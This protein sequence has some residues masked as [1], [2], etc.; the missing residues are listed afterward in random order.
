MVI[1]TL[2]ILKRRSDAVNF[3]W[4]DIA[5]TSRCCRVILVALLLT[6]ALVGLTPQ[7]L[8][9]SPELIAAIRQYKLLDHQGKY[10]DAE[11]FAKRALE[12]G[13]VEFGTSHQTYADLLSNLA[14]LYQSQGRYG[15]AEP[16][17]KSSLSIKEKA[18]GPDHPSLATSLMNLSE[19]Y[20]AQGRYGEAEPLYLGSLAIMEKSLGPDHPSIATVRN[21]LAE[22]YRKQGRYGEAEPLYKRSLVIAENTLGSGHRHVA[23]TLNN[24]AL[25]YQSQ[26][27][28]GEAEPLYLRS[29]AIREKVLDP[30]HPDVGQSLSNLAVLYM[31]QGRYGEAEPFYKRVLANWKKSLGPD[32]PNVGQS[33][34]NLAELYRKQG[35][36]AEAEPLYK[37]SLTIKEK[38]LVPDHPSVA[39][40]L[41]NLAL[42]YQSQG[43]YGEAEPLLKSSLSIS[44]KSLGPDHPN[45]A[46]SLNNLALLYRSQGKIAQSL[47]HIRRAAAIQRDRA[48]RTGGGEGWGRLSEQKSIRHTFLFHVQDA[49]AMSKT[50]PS[51][52]TA[53]IA[54]GFAS[55]QLATASSAGAAVSRMAARF[56]TGDDA[57]AGLVRERQDVA[58]RW[59]RLDGALV[60]AASKPPDRRDR[61]REATQRLELAKTDRRI[62]KIDAALAKSFPQYAELASPKP[63]PLD[64]LQELLGETEALLTYLVGSKRSFVFVVRRDRFLAKEVNLRAQELDDA[65]AVLRRGL[66]PFRIRS[67]TDV[68]PFNTTVAYEL[69]QKIFEPIE[70]LLEGARQVFVVPDGALQSLPLGVL[71]SQDFDGEIK[72]PGDYGKVPWL[73]R[74]YAMT[75]LPSVSSLRA[76]RTFARRT[77]A[78]RSF[79][80]V[81]DPQLDGETG[82]SR[83]V[84]LASLFTLRGVA[85]VASVRR[86]PSLPDTYEELQSMA[87]S[88]GADDG[89]LMVGADA[90]ETKIKSMTLTDY[91]VLTF[92]THGLLAG[93]LTG[94]SEP[95]LVLTP[96]KEGTEL[97]DGLLTASEVAQLKLDADWVILS[98]CNTAAADGTPGAE[99]LSGLAKAFFYAGARSLLVSHWPVVSDAAVK[100]TT[101][102]LRVLQE[103]GVSRAEA[104]RQAKLALMNGAE[105]PAYAHPMFWA[106]F[107]LVGEGQ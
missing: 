61:A 106:P 107:V 65:V 34:N 57:L 38:S 100:T 76:L 7:A 36:Y 37:R 24:L 90:T 11:P 74:T 70:D 31:I 67:L 2:T 15:E 79:L 45:V 20:R 92:A 80:G 73:A 62:K 95:A 35:R 60:K 5:R 77:R 14:L 3:N 86:L 81:G 46:Q 66:D 85:D 54:E 64:E 75:T 17:L 6:F 49:L 48:V 82:S 91:K 22:L 58:E 94:L 30:D 56:A 41:N 21:N 103:P 63:V 99:G 78:S 68:P 32:H 9:Q 1:G 69:Y 40:S 53:L 19:L 39:V 102:M 105:H 25:L 42:L 33:L 96:P 88:L 27:R 16:L 10:A 89:A 97:D 72:V 23:T 52:R 47:D 29:L 43:R 101:L 28:Y 87:Q 18:L 26:G 4:N 50:Q 93:D 12:L 71:V 104:L 8:A 98:A 44:E 51:G 13:E 84:N 55:G 59:R 83:G